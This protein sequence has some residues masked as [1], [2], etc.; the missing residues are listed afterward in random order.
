MNNIFVL[1]VINT[2]L[3]SIFF[4]MISSSALKYYK[5][6]ILL[7]NLN[8]KEHVLFIYQDNNINRLYPICQFG[9]S[10]HTDRNDFPDQ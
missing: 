4:P 6:V 8:R 1:V 10:I 5:V 3:R 7:G 9:E 2:S